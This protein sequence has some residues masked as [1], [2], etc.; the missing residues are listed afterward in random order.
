VSQATLDARANIWTF[1]IE[2][3]SALDEHRHDDWLALLTEDFIY[4]MPVPRSQ[5]DPGRSPYDSPNFLAHESKSFL[6]MRFAR[7]A[8]DHAWSERPT[9][10]IRHFVSNLRVSEGTETDHWEVSTNVLVARS[11]LPE[12]TTISTAGRRDTIVL[13]P[14]G[15]RLKHRTV[16]LDTEVPTDS[17]LGFIY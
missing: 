13:T 14:E 6:E 2:E 4:E 16:Y 9:A 10:F 5:E 12:G 7:V 15:P 17:Q 1:L 3:A 11:R 8:S